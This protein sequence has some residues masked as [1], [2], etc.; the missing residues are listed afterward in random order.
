M[1]RSRLEQLQE[2]VRVDP[3]A[4]IDEALAEDDGLSSMPKHTPR[5]RLVALIVALFFLAISIFAAGYSLF[6][7]PP[8]PD[9]TRPLPPMIPH[10]GAVRPPGV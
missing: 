8:H 9:R 2:P 4:W 5:R 1:T 6:G 10:Q 3:P 7:P